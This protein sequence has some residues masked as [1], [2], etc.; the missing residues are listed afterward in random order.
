MVAPVY[1]SLDPLTVSK[2]CF[3]AVTQTLQEALLNFNTRVLPGMVP[4]VSGS[5]R[6]GGMGAGSAGGALPLPLPCRR[7]PRRA[8][9]ATPRGTAAVGWVLLAPWPRPAGMHRPSLVLGHARRAW[10]K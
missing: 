8:V 3:F 9:R 2:L 5:R 6:N 7:C 1:H 10:K 4:E